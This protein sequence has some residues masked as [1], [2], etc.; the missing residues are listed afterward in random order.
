MR[1]GPE[2]PATRPISLTPLIDVVFILLVFFMLA[3]SFL[4]WHAVDLKLSG[5]G[6]AEASTG[7]SLLVQIAESGRL[8]LDGQDRSV[9]QLEAEVSRRLD[10]RPDLPVVLRPGPGVSLQR[11]VD[12][13][14]L[15]KRA[16]AADVALSRQR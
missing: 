10:A 9:E 8:R 11:T 5:S 7:E 16:G 6:S 1:F 2:E 13:L 4:D 3:S 14:D 12:V 15:L